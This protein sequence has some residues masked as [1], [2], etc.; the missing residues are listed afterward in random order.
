MTEAQAKRVE[1]FKRRVS[2]RG[3]VDTPGPIVAKGG[4]GSPATFD[5][6]VVIGWERSRDGRDMRTVIDEHGRTIETRPQYSY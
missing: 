1:Q 6:V 5:N 2:V 4:H 3:V